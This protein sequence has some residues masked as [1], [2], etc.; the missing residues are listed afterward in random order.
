MLHSV[1]MCIP[2][3]Y[4]VAAELAGRPGGLGVILE[5]Y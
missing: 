2:F 1:A 4:F 5:C 3:S